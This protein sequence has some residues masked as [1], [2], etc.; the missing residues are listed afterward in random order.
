MLG[1][2]REKLKIGTEVHQQLVAFDSENSS[3]FDSNTTN[4]KY[5]VLLKRMLNKVRYISHY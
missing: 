2:I 4:V 3:Y 1:A 5:H